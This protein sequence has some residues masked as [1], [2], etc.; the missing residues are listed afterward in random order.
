M[1]APTKLPGS[2]HYPFPV[3]DRTEIINRLIRQ[4]AEGGVQADPLFISHFYTTLKAQRLVILAGPAN[5][6]KIALVQSLAQVVTGSN[7]FQYQM[8][9]GHAWWA[10]QSGDVGFFTQAQTRFN[11]EK[12]M[13]VVGEALQ[14]RNAQQV[15]IVCLTRISRAEIID[16]FADLVSQIRCGQLI[17]LPHFHLAKP[18]P[19][20]PNLL[21]VGTMDT[22]KF[23]G[24]DTGPGSS[25]TII[26]WPAIRSERGNPDPIPASRAFFGSEKGSSSL[27][28]DPVCGMDVA[29]E[30][31][32]GKSEHCGQT[33]YFCSHGCKKAFDQK[34]ETYCAQHNGITKNF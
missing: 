20:P 11:S 26:A 2:T 24:V 3:D 32:A 27:P 6:G 12:I 4:A 21:L 18:I 1:I 19:Y 15:F 22:P 30:K 14:P 17:R 25:P 34:P 5:S 16:F 23:D 29:K 10:G 33:Y 28:T 7:P 31:A 8:M 9:V 13:A